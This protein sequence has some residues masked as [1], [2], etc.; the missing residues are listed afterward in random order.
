[1]RTL[2]ILLTATSLAAC[3]G[4]GASSIGSASSSSVGTPTPTGTPAV[5]DAY[6]QFASPTV[7]KTYAGVGGS[8]VFQYS[9]DA[10]TPTNGSTGLTGFRGQ[11]A[12]TYASNGSTVRDSKIAVT[13]DPSGATFTLT[14]TDPLSG[15]GAA[16]RFQD[17]ASRTN[18]GGTVEPQ[19]GNDNFA[20]YPGVGKNSNIRFLQAGDGA[21]LSP[22]SRSGTGFINPGTNKIAP[23]GTSGSS[24]QSANLFYDPPG[25]ANKYVTLAGYVR[26]AITWQDITVGTTNYLQTTYK[27]E[28]GAFVYGVP[29]E[30]NSVPKVGS[31]TY[32]GAMLATMVFNPTIDGSTAAQPLTGG[33]LPTYF[34]WIS[35]T[36]T[37]TVNFA[38]N[39]LALSLN[40]IVGAGQFDANTTPQQ[41]SIAPGTTFT[42]SGNATINL[43][44]TG[45]FSGAITSASFGGTTNG[46]SPT[47]NVI[48][49]SINGTFYG[50]NGEEIGGGFR[51]VGGTPDQRVDILGAF[52]AAKP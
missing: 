25:A 36:S 42:A 21:P 4:G 45:G 30:Q 17:P 10:R 3:G 22:Y 37:A 31:G 33:D 6:A 7:T 13:Y 18:F 38:S 14:V 20:A 44:T 12:S 34:Q 41:T 16:T 1:M 51:V 32:T 47:V 49:S 39:S 40:G 29:T 11:Q 5:V 50:P 26:N 8:Q 27:L 24:Y 9:V 52:K 23:S 46:A 43:V 19:W 2:A 35:G 15:A 28:R 48:G